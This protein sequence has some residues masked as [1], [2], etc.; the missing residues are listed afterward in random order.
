M[1]TYN[2]VCRLILRKSSNKSHLHD[3]TQE[4]HNLF[5]AY[6]IDLKA[7]WIQIVRNTEVDPLRPQVN[8]DD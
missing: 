6:K 8:H 4:I 2:Y 5:C 7:C 3:L 1:R